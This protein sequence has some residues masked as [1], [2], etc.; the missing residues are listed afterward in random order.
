MQSQFTSSS[1]RVILLC[2]RPAGKGG[3]RSKKSKCKPSLRVVHSGC[4][5]WGRK[6][7]NASDRCPPFPRPRPHTLQ[8]GKI[9]ATRCSQVSVGQTE[10]TLSH[11]ADK[12]HEMYLNEMIDINDVKSRE[13]DE[14]RN[15]LWSAVERHHHRTY[16]RLGIL[17][18]SCAVGGDEL[19]L[20]LGLRPGGLDG[21]KLSPSSPTR[22]LITRFALPAPY[23]KT[24]CS[25]ACSAPTKKGRAKRQSRA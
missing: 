7:E 13:G 1:K 12:G 18:S 5:E 15:T 23:Q 16:I 4:W 14:E 25:K 6:G 2:T 22:Y 20:G 24:R 10:S 17:Y 3:A 11:T 19:R 21:V 9:I 8:L